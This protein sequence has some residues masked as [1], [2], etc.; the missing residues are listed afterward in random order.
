MR[1]TPSIHR[2]ARR[3]PLL[4]LTGLL[5]LFVLAEPVYAMPGGWGLGGPGFAIVLAGFFG[6]LFS[7]VG[8]LTYSVVKALKDGPNRDVWRVVAC[9]LTTLGV[10][11][12]WRLFR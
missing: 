10:Y 2:P 3:A 4:A 11:V 5:A 1:T 12:T 9:G 6:A 8:F 7:Y